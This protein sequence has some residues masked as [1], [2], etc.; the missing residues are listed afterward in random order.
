MWV[1][2]TLGFFV[3]F[4]PSL[5]L[6]LGGGVKRGYMG[7]W[8]GWRVAMPNLLQ[9]LALPVPKLQASSHH[10]NHPPPNTHHHPKKKLSK[11]LSIG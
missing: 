2:F 6:S 5:S 8:Q 9:G 7:G 4:S 1:Y 3:S 11:K 10:P